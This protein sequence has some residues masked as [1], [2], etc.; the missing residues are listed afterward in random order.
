[1][2]GALILAG[3]A[4]RE[5][6]PAPADAVPADGARMDGAR[7]D[8]ARMDGARMDGARM[9]GGPAAAP[10]GPPSGNGAAARPTPADS[11]GAA[12]RQD[13]I[14]RA[15]ADLPS[16]PPGA[17]WRVFETGQPVTQDLRPERLD[18]EIDPGRQVVVRLRC[19]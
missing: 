5:S 13:W 8:G 19:G 17:V 16:P 4:E 1:M 10:A 11:C 15:R 3:C 14:G 7:M 18:I 2:A 6:S 12:A 9:D